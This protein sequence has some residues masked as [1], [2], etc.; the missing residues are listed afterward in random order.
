[1]SFD[2]GRVALFIFFFVVP[3]IGIALGLRSPAMRSRI[4]IITA[5]IAGMI[6]ILS[7][8]IPKGFLSGPQ[9]MS[10]RLDRWLI[11][12]AGFAL[13]L[14]IVN[15]VQNNSRRIA[16]RASMRRSRNA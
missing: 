11:I 6:P 9:G 13:L 5:F 4:P 1:M 14:G 10:P 15:V 2:F 12:V 7:L 8:Y 16:R 3:V